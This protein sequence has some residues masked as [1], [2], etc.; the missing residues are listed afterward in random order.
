MDLVIERNSGI[1][2]QA[3]SAASFVA[4]RAASRGALSPWQVRC[5][6]VYIEDNLGLPVRCTDMASRVG[7]SLSHFMRCFRRSFGCSPHVFLMRRRMERAQLLMVSTRTRLADIAFDCG[8][9]DQAHLSRSF[10]KF[11]GQSPAAWRRAQQV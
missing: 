8:M 9:A 4:P 10:H 5:L 1:D 3:H 11:F 6:T 7:L 2:I